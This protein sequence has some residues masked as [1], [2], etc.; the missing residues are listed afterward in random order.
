MIFV[1]SRWVLMFFMIMFMVYIAA[2]IGVYGKEGVAL[3]F[4]VLRSAALTL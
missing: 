2:A 3:L 4:I 1:K